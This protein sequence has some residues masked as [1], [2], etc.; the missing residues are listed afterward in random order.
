MLNSVT[1]RNV[2]D[3]L[4]TISIEKE[5]CPGSFFSIVV[6]IDQNG[7]GS[8]SSTGIKAFCRHCDEDCHSSCSHYSEMI[9]AASAADASKIEEEAEDE[10]LNLDFHNAAIDGMESLILAAACQG[11]DIGSAAF[12]KAIETTL[13]AISNEHD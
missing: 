7:V 13:E 8:I 2:E 1:I 6:T 12:L 3:G 5:G 4:V 11:V 10:A 9:S